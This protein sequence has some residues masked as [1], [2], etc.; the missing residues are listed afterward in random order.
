MYIKIGS[1]KVIEATE[2]FFNDLSVQADMLGADADDIMFSTLRD[3]RDKKVFCDIWNMALCV[4]D[5]NYPY[6]M[7]NEKEFERISKYLRV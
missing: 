5:T 7:I 1:E 6:V 4:K 3:N 2:K